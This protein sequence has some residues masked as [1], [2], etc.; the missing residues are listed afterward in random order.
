MSTAPLDFTREAPIVD[1]HVTARQIDEVVAAP[2]DRFP[3]RRW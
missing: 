2:L 3:S 1:G